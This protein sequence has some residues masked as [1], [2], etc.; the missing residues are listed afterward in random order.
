M[1]RLKQRACGF[2]RE[3]NARDYTHYNSVQW[4]F[5]Q[6]AT[7]AFVQVFLL[8]FTEAGVN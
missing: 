2:E 5:G 6:I 4:N 1:S 7:A 3:I 8:P